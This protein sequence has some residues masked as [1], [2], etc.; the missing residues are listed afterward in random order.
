MVILQ[1]GN[2]YNNTDRHKLP[3]N[4]LLGWYYWLPSHRHCTRTNI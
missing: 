3:R 4:S 1:A 2:R